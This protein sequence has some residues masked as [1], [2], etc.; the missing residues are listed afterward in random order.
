MRI[1]M[2]R[3]QAGSVDG[4]RIDTYQTGAEYDMGKT[5]KHT[6]LAR[7]FLREGWAEHVDI[8]VDHKDATTTRLAARRVKRK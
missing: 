6:D 7:V 1:R 4:Y 3:T 2:L 8:R 5:E